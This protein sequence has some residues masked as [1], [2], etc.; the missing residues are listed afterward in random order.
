MANV[1]RTAKERQLYHFNLSKKGAC[2]KNGTK[3]SDFQRGRHFGQA[4]SILSARART[5][6]YYQRKSGKNV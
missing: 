5:A 4:E 1:K 2:T 3:L 6:K